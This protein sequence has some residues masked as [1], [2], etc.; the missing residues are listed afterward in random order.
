MSFLPCSPETSFLC[1][2][3]KLLVVLPTT[4]TRFPLPLTRD[5][6]FVSGL[7]VP[8]RPV[9]FLKRKMRLTV[10]LTDFPKCVPLV[11]KIEKKIKNLCNRIV[12]VELKCLPFLLH[13]TELLY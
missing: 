1:Q 9:P 7:T 2:L 11:L 8:G 6:P 5:S 4:L 13:C 12:R 3:Y 10:L